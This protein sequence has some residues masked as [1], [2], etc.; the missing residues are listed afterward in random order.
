MILIIAR[1][2][3][4]VQQRE[5]ITTPCT[6]AHQQTSRTWSTATLLPRNPIGV[7]KADAG[8]PAKHTG[9]LVGKWRDTFQCRVLGDSE[10]SRFLFPGGTNSSHFDVAATLREDN[11]PESLKGRHDF[12]RRKPLEFRHTPARLPA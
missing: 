12:G 6:I 11:K 8:N 1:S 4:A 3:L 10:R 9:N 5:F 7:R 2:R